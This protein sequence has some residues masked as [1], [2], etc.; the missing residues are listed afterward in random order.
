[1]RTH[2]P[3]QGARG[4]AN[5]RRAPYLSSED[6]GHLPRTS[7]K[8]QETHG[9]EGPTGSGD[10][11]RDGL[12]GGGG[13]GD[14][15]DRWRRD[16]LVG[17]RRQRYHVLIQ[18]HDLRLPSLRPVKATGTRRRRRRAAE[19]QETFV[20]FGGGWK[21]RMCANETVGARKPAT[22]SVPVH[23]ERVGPGR[24]ILHTSKTSSK[25]ARHVLS[26]AWVDS[27]D[28]KRNQRTTFW[29]AE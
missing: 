25:T 8:G 19:G 5:T 12:D 29:R 3:W 28:C 17:G 11:R 27:D 16:V 13:R 7:G 15:G 1:M 21:S 24:N 10:G 23:D 26:Y 4:K 6:I 2:I 18:H 22:A 20:P 9:L 14:G